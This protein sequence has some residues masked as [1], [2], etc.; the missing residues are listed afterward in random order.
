MYR[1]GDGQV[2]DA[3]VFHPDGDGAGEEIGEILLSQISFLA[4]INNVAIMIIALADEE[5]G[6]A[7][8]CLE[9]EGV[10]IAALPSIQAIVQHGMGVFILEVEG[11]F[12]VCIL[13]CEE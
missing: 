5:L 10:Q 7:N 3:L 9:G 6:S 12:P 4:G 2:A 13:S 11:V 8:V 1:L